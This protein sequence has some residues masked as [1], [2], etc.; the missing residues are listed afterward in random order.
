MLEMDFFFALVRVERHIQLVQLENKCYDN[1]GFRHYHTKTGI[2][3]YD[4]TKS[5]FLRMSI[6]MKRKSQCSCGLRRLKTMIINEM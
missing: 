2:N 1:G 3:V 4:Y 5:S 6:C